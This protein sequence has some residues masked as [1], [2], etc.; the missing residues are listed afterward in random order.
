MRLP[1]GKTGS[2]TSASNNYTTLNLVPILTGVLLPSMRI[3]PTHVTEA[4]NHI[5][6]LRT[7]LGQNPIDVFGKHFLS[8]QP[9]PAYM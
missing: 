1:L 8:T 7:G 3:F 4:Q 9:L 6:S 2:Q 5:R